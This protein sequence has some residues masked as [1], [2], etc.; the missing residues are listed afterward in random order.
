MLNRLFQFY[1]DSPAT[2]RNLIVSVAPVI[3]GALKPFVRSI[4]FDGITMFLDTRDNA[5]FRYLRHRGN[6]EPICVGAMK[7]AVAHNPGSI[8]LDAGA[9]YGFFTLAIAGT[10]APGTLIHAYAFEPD[11]RSSAAL[12]KSIAANRFENR[13]TA[14]QVILGDEDGTARLFL[15][16]RASTSNRTFKTA[17]PTVDVS[18][19]VELPSMRIDTFLA[20]VDV[21]DKYIILKIDVEGN[22]LRVLKGARETLKKC[23]GYVVLFEYY[24]VGIREVGQD[25]EEFAEV[26]KDLK[27][28][29]AQTTNAIGRSFGLH[30]LNGLPGLL[31]DMTLYSDQ[32]DV[33]KAAVGHATNYII[34]RG[35][36]P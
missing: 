1:A 6:Y 7:S 11:T 30:S 28:E 8:F 20:D 19:S 29:W 15:S 34:G 22:E 14:K 2:T 4:R 12:N 27:P 3:R 10:S 16:N 23:K 24:P 13:V 17:G 26:L 36:K 5:I 21:C 18:G 9:S 35:T 31:E 33:E 32:P 25:S